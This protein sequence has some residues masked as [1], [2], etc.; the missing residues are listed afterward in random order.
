MKVGLHADAVGHTIPGGIGSYVRRLGD[1][2]V[3]HPQDGTDVRMLVAR[4][5]KLPSGWPD[6]S[7]VSSPLPLRAMYASWNVL[8]APKLAG[9]D[10][11]HAT[12]LVIPPARGAR[13]VATIHDD[14]VER[15]PELV[16]RFWR[17]LYRRGFRI[18]LHEA[19][20]LCAN[21]E[22]TKRRLV[23]E[24]GVDAGRVTVTPLAPLVSPG[25]REN[26]GVLE[27]NGIRSPYLLHVGTL[28][29][30]KNQAA[31]VRAFARARLVSHHLVCAGAP[32]WGASD[33]EAAIASSGKAGRIVVTGRV[34]DEELAALYAHADAFAFPSVYEGFG[35]PL[36]EA[37]AYGLPSA[38]S[39]DDALRE[40]GADA[41]ITADP[42]DEAAFARALI[43]ICTDDELRS[44][45]R[46]TGPARAAHYSWAAC[47][48]ATRSAWR[49]ALQ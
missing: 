28:E 38:T 29:P 11:V 45:L 18:A 13:L 19:A 42:R 44:E 24:Y 37:L 25:H 23:G 15:F 30:R 4:G 41:V 33:I 9:Y 47:A 17:G 5:T 14:T 22:A 32:G 3:N 21:S 16:P 1:E 40:V 27:R 39:N 6:E 43:R 8:R 35:M 2:L 31:L 49:G 48:E 26:A 34:T 46:A 10:V 20:V 12:G 7:A 36:L